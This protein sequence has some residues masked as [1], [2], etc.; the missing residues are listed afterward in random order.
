MPTAQCWATVELH[1]RALL[2]GPIQLSYIRECS[3]QITL[4]KAIAFA[5][6]LPSGV[7]TVWTYSLC[8]P[9]THCNGL[10][11]KVDSAAI[12]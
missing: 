8:N 12:S 7:Q 10:S 2:L 1:Q 5:Q 6:G 3:G 4:N 11:G 9:M